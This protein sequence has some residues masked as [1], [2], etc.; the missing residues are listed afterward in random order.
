MVNQQSNPQKWQLVDKALIDAQKSGLL[1]SS[2]KEICRNVF[3]IFFNLCF[4]HWA[5]PVLGDCEKL[6]WKLPGRNFT[7]MQISST[8][9]QY[10]S[11]FMKTTTLLLLL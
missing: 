7:C 6:L 8:H 9:K 1:Q 4:N 11:K 10:F 2:N 3:F 5:H